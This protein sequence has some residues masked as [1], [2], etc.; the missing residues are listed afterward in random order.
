MAA[1][2]GVAMSDLFVLYEAQMRWI[3]PSFRLLHSVP[4]ADDRRV[5][6]GI[7]FIIKNGLRWRA[8]VVSR[9]G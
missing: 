2:A 5:I 7:I 8:R 3:E 6:S 4:R 9:A 1:H